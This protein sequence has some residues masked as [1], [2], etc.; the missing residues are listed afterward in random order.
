MPVPSAPSNDVTKPYRVP[1]QGQ[2]VWEIA[3]QTLG[4]PR[5]WSEIY[6]LNNSLRPEAPIPGGTEIRLPASANVP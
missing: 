3:Q 1:A 4:D 2:M 5:R 6:R